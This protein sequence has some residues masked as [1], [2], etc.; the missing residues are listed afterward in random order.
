M[1]KTLIVNNITVEYRKK[2]GIKDASFDA[3]D[4]EIIGFIGADG[5]GKSSLLHAIAGTI[6]FR[7]EVIYKGYSYHSP[8]EAENIKQFIGFM[9]QGIGLVLYPLLTVK[10]HLD[11]FTAI[12]N[13]KKDKNYWQYRESLLEM[14]GLSEFQDRLAKNLS[15]GMQQKLSLICTLI[16][17]PK[18]LIADEPTTGVDPLSRRKLWEIIDDNRKKEGIIAIVST[19]YMRDAEKMDKI[20]LFD[21]GMV[22][23]KGKGEELKN[24][25]AENVYI[26]T[27]CSDGCFTF[28]KKTYS[29]K[30]LNAPHA[31]PE[32]EDIFFIT[33]LKKY[34]DIPDIKIEDRE[35]KADI[36]EVVMEAK[37]L[38][39]RFGSFVANKNID[40]IIKKGEIVGLLGP[41][42]AG[43]TT[44][45]KMLLG[46]LP[47]DEGELIL[48]G[49]KIKSYKDRLELKSKI[50]YV[51]Q[52]FALYN[53]MTVQENLIY[54]SNIHQ[55]PISKALSR[56]NN[57][58]KGLRF[59]EYLNYLPSEL[60]LGI[61]QRI[62]VAV[63]L[64]HEPL[65]LFLDEPTSGVDA[66]AR[67]QLWKLLHL[68]KVKWVI[69]ILITTH[70][71]SEAEYCDRVVLFK[72]GEKV[73]DSTIKELYNRF[74]D[75]KNFEEIFVKFYK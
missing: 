67:A 50:G 25:I 57:L 6:K 22:I 7:G 14:A 65:I 32:L 3:E 29:I 60:P 17:K 21:E 11:F 56:I 48:L 73:A 59:E 74:P 35:T 2:I 9:P 49:K 61:N 52:R 31:K 33:A 46:L 12:R 58:A 64:I 51:S 44:F 13:I 24:S 16:H 8:S 75:A 1:M 53:D 71:M 41:N 55:I 23:A 27:S 19:G 45:I 30:P 54:F 36:P 38:T 26:E 4:G 37:G 72:D 66:I 28:N 43:K 15:G 42:G 10:E 68:L 18:L 70:Y 5:S 47:I 39:K 63:A 40:M 34:K 20:L 62:S 69:S